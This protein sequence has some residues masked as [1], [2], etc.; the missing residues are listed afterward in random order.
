MPLLDVFDFRWEKRREANSPT[1]GEP[2]GKKKRKKER[3][4]WRLSFV[5]KREKDL[6]LWR[7]VGLR[8]CPSREREGGETARPHPPSQRRREKGEK[9]IKLI[10]E[11]H[12]TRDRGGKKKKRGGE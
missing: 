4:W 7:R 12:S 11:R 9:L 6:L 5:E 1:K 8:G 3:E 10:R 2:V